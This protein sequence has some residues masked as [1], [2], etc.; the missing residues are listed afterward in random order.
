MGGIGSGPGGLPRKKVARIKLALANGQP[1][2]SIARDTGVDRKVIRKIARG[3]H[4]SELPFRDITQK[5]LWFA[6][7]VAH[8]CIRLHDTVANSF[9][10]A[11]GARG[12]VTNYH[13]LIH[14]I[15][16]SLSVELAVPEM[17]AF[18]AL[19]VNAL[20]ADVLEFI[21]YAHD[22]SYLPTGPECWGRRFATA[23]EVA[24]EALLRAENVLLANQV[25]PNP[26][27]FFGAAAPDV[28][29]ELCR[30]LPLLDDLGELSTD[31]RREWASA[32][33]CLRELRDSD[34]LPTDNDQRASG[35]VTHSDL[36][37]EF[38]VKPDAA[39]KKLDRWRKLNLE[40]SDWRQVT[41]RAQ[42]EASYYYRRSAVAHLFG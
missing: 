11:S 9:V 4:C 30:D 6:R 35:F 3:E 41:E 8:N 39:R 23:H 42:N 27:K 13:K 12:Q 33:N 10:T 7:D 40:S 24:F 37:R 28:L 22:Q 20:A 1:Q 15:A 29:A 34:P 31:L 2:T 5:R 14:P 17:R 18:G 21:G 26:A 38:G 32:V 19:A 36:A 16:P 25:L